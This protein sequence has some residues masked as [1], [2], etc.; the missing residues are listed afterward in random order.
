[1]K[2]RRLTTEE[3]QELEQEFIRFLAANTVTGDDWEQIKKESPQK[4]EGLIDIFSDIVFE[5]IIGQVE[6]LEFKM[7]KDYKTFYCQA[8]KITLIGLKLSENSNLDFTQNETL[9]RLMQ[10]LNQ[11]GAQLQIYSAEKEYKPD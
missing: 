1:M 2:F 3:L 7:P 10:K 6:Y 4:A 8:D 5:K 11:G 9:E